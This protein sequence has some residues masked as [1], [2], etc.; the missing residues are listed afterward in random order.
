MK[1]RSTQLAYLF[2]LAVLFTTKG[3][4]QQKTLV[5]LTG[6]ASYNR[7]D[8]KYPEM[9]DAKIGYGIEAN[10]MRFVH[11]NIYVTTGLSYLRKGY[12]V[13][14]IPDTR[15]FYS[16]SFF[17]NNILYFS[18]TYNLNYVSL[19]LSVGLGILNKE[20]SKFSLFVNAGL[21]LNYMIREKITSHLSGGDYSSVKQSTNTSKNFSSAVTS[22][23]TLFYAVSD[24]VYLMIKPAY[25]YDFYQADTSNV[26]LHSFSLSA[27]VQYQL[28]K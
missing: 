9:F 14:N 26:K 17:V 8:S 6:L 25:S 20:E 3:Y 27:G 18:Q 16:N 4:A 7:V 1:K 5:G 10:V 19:P 28:K 12:T 21:Q 15:A 13:K 11:K 2:L 24:R 23:L 22:G